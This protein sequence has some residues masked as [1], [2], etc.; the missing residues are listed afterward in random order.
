MN[1]IH[2]APLWSP[3]DQLSPGS[4]SLAQRWDK[5]RTEAREAVLPRRKCPV[6]PLDM[7]VRIRE[8][9][10]VS[11]LPTLQAENGTWEGRTDETQLQCDPSNHAVVGVDIPSD[12]L[13]HFGICSGP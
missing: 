9:P 4:A 2:E 8:R 1:A 5:L 3:G 11:Y 10:R 6:L 12:V 7:G 13:N